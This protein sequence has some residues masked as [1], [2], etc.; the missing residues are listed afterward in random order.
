MIKIKGTKTRLSTG[1][2]TFV[3]MG[4]LLAVIA[5]GSWKIT[6][7][8]IVFDSNVKNPPSYY[9]GNI[10]S[11]WQKLQSEESL[12]IGGLHIHSDEGGGDSEEDEVVAAYKSASYKNSDGKVN[13]AFDF[14]FITEHNQLADNVA[15]KNI[16][17]I[18]S[19]EVGKLGTRSKKEIA[20]QISQSK[21]KCEE[22][23]GV[24]KNADEDDSQCVYKKSE[25]EGAKVSSAAVE[26][27]EDEENDDILIATGLF[28]H[29][30]MS[31]I[32][33]WKAL[34][35]PQPYREKY[36]HFGALGI[37]D[38]IDPATGPQKNIDKIR[39][40][41][42]IPI[43]NH[44]R[45]DR[46]KRSYI[47]KGLKNINIMEIFNAKVSDKT[48]KYFLVL[49]DHLLTKGK[50]MFGVA[51]DDMHKLK[52][53]EAKKG[54]IGVKANAK[55]KKEILNAIDRGKFYSST[56]IEIKDYYIENNQLNVESVN[57]NRIIF[58]GEEGKVLKDVQNSKSGFYDI[59]G[60]EKYIRVEVY[61][62]NEK[63]AAF[64]QPYFVDKTF[65]GIK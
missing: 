28:S 41:G 54:W 32:N 6:Q 2:F 4:V 7:D 29:L 49:W 48:N 65:F 52:N 44:P 36:S 57:G 13:P 53:G 42:G 25:D 39:K 17:A 45:P 63:K 3:G 20:S 12:L 38:D 31:W 16:V 27:I 10:N 24:W 62:S 9:V 55:T 8:K 47:L 50:I 1:L 51:T 30:N 23:D 14:V 5:G 46:I 19:E 40:V 60:S 11:G 18:P 22:N 58:V 34:K 21:K 61:N 59:T 33:R 64:I 26:N 56:G 37:D 15:L 43:L 35:E